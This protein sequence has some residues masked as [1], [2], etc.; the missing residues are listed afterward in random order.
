MVTSFGD[1]ADLD[2]ALRDLLSHYRPECVEA[3]M[4]RS[5]LS[6]SVPYAFEYAWLN[7]LTLPVDASLSS[8]HNLMTIPNDRR[9]ELLSVTVERASGDNTCKDLDIR[10]SDEYREGTIEDYRLLR[11]SSTDTTIFWPDR[12]GAQ[13]VM[14]SVPG[15][16]LL[17]PGTIVRLVPG[18]EGVSAST[19]DCRIVLR[20]TKLVRARGPST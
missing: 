10:A 5:L 20:Y 9:A 13:T 6:F 7:G 15:P 11:L 18:G 12:G 1:I 14:D 19:F 3:V 2:G 17:E 8:A 16:E 4:G